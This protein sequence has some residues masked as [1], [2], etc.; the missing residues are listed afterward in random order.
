MDANH[1]L[2]KSFKKTFISGDEFRLLHDLKRRFVLHRIDADES[3]FKLCRLQKTHTT[4][5]KVSVIVAHDAHTI[6]YSDPSVK[7]NDTI[8]L[9]IASKKMAS[10]LKFELGSLLTIVRGR[11]S[12]SYQIQTCHV[13]HDSIMIQI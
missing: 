7:V 11:N 5:G 1:L 8:K 6:C 13:T 3:K 9:D 2:I 10:F 12:G 4:A